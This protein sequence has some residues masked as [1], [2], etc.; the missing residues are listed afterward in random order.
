MNA[1]GSYLTSITSIIAMRHWIACLLLSGLV[2]DSS[3]QNGQLSLG[4]S[5]MYHPYG[6]MGVGGTL[7]HRWRLG[8]H[9]EAIGQLTAMRV[10]SLNTR[11]N[12]EHNTS[13]MEDTGP[14]NLY[15]GGIGL[16]Y[17]TGGFHV[18]LL[19]GGMG[20]IGTGSNAKAPQVAPALGLTTGQGIG[21]YLDVSLDTWFLRSEAQQ[22][23]ALPMPRVAFNLGR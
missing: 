15:F 8:E 13:S 12:D 7:D 21:R 9:V 18:G 17:R 14:W 16:G 1:I 6:V 3:A 22:I 19:A 4:V 2:H 5:S 10:W 23:V 20:Y 11:R